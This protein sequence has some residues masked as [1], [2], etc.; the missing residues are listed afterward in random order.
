MKMTKLGVLLVGMVAL[1]GCGN[2][3]A[4]EKSVDS[5]TKASETM[6]AEEATIEGKE[7][8]VYSAGPDG[9]SEKMKV[10]FEEKTGVKVNLFQ[11]TTGKILAK[12]EAEKGKPIADVVVLASLSS[13]DS[14]KQAGELQAYPDALGKEHLTVEWTDADDFYFGYSASALGITYNTKNVTDIPKDWSDLA[15]ASW[16][17][18]FNMPDPTLSGS[19]LDFLYGYTTTDQ[20]WETIT[21]WFDNG[22]QIMGAN[23]S[24]LD[25]VIT[26]EKNAT[27]S[28][29]DYMAYKAKADGEPVD[30]VYPE[31]G[32]VVSPRAVGITK[33][34]K[35]LAAS[36][37]FVDF[38]LSDEGQEL[39][40]DAYLLPGNS[41]I[42]VKD[43]AAL[44]EIK[45]ID[46]E[47]KD[48]EEKQMD[49]LQKF[50]SISQK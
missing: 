25:A 7:I 30:I 20:G 19:A 32:T 23:K 16:Q 44:D 27:I 38:L 37:A 8:T 28:G 5:T 33:S 3:N 49:V 35:E 15:D 17:E 39:V 41:N 24:A 48:S 47:W 18:R 9:L 22:M 11:G 1:A 42:A 13:M 21:S 31:S 29:V 46:V 50:A 10:A 4:T 26:G 40:A 36:Q 45:Q 43:R 34:A 6:S 14:L 12:L 2:S